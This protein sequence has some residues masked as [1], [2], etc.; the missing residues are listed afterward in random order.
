[1]LLSFSLHITLPGSELL[2][3]ITGQLSTQ[4]ALQSPVELQAQ[5]EQGDAVTREERSERT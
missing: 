3:M 1:M 4:R 5:S 2:F